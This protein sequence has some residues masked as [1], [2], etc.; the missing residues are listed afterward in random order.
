MI[1][2]T[3]SDNTIAE[4]QFTV[5][6]NS[7]Y[8]SA[9]ITVDGNITSCG[10]F[11]SGQGA[12]WIVPLTALTYVDQIAVYVNGMSFLIQVIVLYPVKKDDIKL[13]LSGQKVKP[14]LYFYYSL[15]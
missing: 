4:S 3:L 10:A 8:Q 2:S 6:G 1:S 5:E 15:I 13:S 14:Q 7:S 12:S 11:L 9:D